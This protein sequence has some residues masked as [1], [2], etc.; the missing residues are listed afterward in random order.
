AQFAASGGATIAGEAHHLHDSQVLGLMGIATV[1]GA[2]GSF[3]AFAM[4]RKGFPK[5]A[6]AFAEGESTKLIYEASKNKLWVDEAYEKIIVE[7][8]RKTCRVLFEAAD[9][10]VIDTFFVGGSAAVV[11][12]G[13]RVVRWFQ[14]GQ[15]QR[16][17]V[18]VVVGAAA[19][20]W[21]ATKPAA[22][23]D[24][25]IKEGTQAIVVLEAGVK[26][27][28]AKDATIEWDW[29][30]DGKADAEGAKVEHDFAGP[31]RYKVT[32]RIVDGVFSRSA[33]KTRVIVVEDPNE[34]DE[35]AEGAEE[36]GE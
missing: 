18:V 13:G 2:I 21:A 1:L 31:G 27:A 34:T 11:D 25:E 35:G 24:Y 14:N 5:R 26:G 6:V 23:F 9:R 22:S 3:V 4:Y 33:E 36:G 15:V 30:G 19:L 28:A 29:T 12:V 10:I 20:F 16:Y 7:P 17:L 8:F 32:V